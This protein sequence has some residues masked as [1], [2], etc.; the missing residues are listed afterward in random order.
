MLKESTNLEVGIICKLAKIS[1]NTKQVLGCSLGYIR[2]G[3][4][5]RTKA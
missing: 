4:V 2:V 5:E 3:F 1:S